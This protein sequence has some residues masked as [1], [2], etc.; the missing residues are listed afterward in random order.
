MTLNMVSFATKNT[1]FVPQ[2]VESMKPS[3]F[4]VHLK[5]F[6]KFILKQINYLFFIF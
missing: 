6:S 4:K 3:K 1:W 2:C 5:M